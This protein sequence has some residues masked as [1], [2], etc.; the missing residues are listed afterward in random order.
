MGIQSTLKP[1]PSI[2]LGVNAVS[3]L[4]LATA[5]A[6]L[7]D[8]GVAHD[9]TILTKVVFPDGHTERASQP[10]GRKIVDPKVVAT[11][12]P[13]YYSDGSPRQAHAPDQADVETTIGGIGIGGNEI[14]PPRRRSVAHFDHHHVPA[15]AKPRCRQIQ[16]RR[17]ERKERLHNRHEI[18]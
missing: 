15:L 18:R 14:T 6:T 3:P 4:D 5:Y 9:P 7:A 12:G 17:L 16:D 8:G 2:V 11:L 13:F 1:V 10:K